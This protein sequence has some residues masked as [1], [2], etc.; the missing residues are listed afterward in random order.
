MK[1]RRRAMNPALQKAA[2]KPV[3]MN[4][5]NM[6]KRQR[7]NHILSTLMIPEAVHKYLTKHTT[8]RCQEFRHLFD[9]MVYGKEPV[10]TAN[11]QRLVDDIEKERKFRGV[12]L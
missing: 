7:N 9:Q 4:F 5:E 2:A 1:G 12:H 6:S 10:N 8:N 11:L 3:M